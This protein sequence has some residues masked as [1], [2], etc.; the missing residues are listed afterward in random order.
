M[1]D[2]MPE[3][4]A[5]TEFVDSYVNKDLSAVAAEFLCHIKHQTAALHSSYHRSLHREFC[6][7]A[8]SPGE[9]LRPTGRDQS[10]LAR[11]LR[12]PTTVAKDWPQRITDA[13][14]P[15]SV[16]NSAQIQHANEG[17]RVPAVV[18]LVEG[19]LKAIC[20]AGLPDDKQPRHSP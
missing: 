14:I 15:S 6:R 11:W 7:P 18:L 1:N 17:I 10:R 20:A 5:G 8:Y 9:F 4:I 19:N 16:Q 2:A 12:T 3:L 13:L